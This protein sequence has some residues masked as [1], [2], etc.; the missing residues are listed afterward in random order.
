[1]LLE[2]EL[3][4]FHFNDVRSVDV[5]AKGIETT[6]PVFDSGSM[7]R[8]TREAFLYPAEHSNIL[9]PKLRT[10]ENNMSLEHS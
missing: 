3:Q 1:M 7:E 6:G 8:E 2:S 5:M 4:R 9:R 10:E